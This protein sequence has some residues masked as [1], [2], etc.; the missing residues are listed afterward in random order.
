MSASPLVVERIAE[1]SNALMGTSKIETFSPAS[2]SNEEEPDTSSH[3]ARAAK[4]SDVPSLHVGESVGEYVGDVVGPEVGEVVGRPVGVA[5]VV[6]VV[7][8]AEVG[9]DVG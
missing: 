5:V 4:N 1:N 2:K 9:P 6:V 8:G 3:G 7:I